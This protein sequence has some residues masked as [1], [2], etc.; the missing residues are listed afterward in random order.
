MEVHLNFLLNEIWRFVPAGKK[1][2]LL[3]NVS[4]LLGVFMLPLNDCIAVILLI[5]SC[6]F[7]YRTLSILTQMK[8]NLIPISLTIL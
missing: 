6:C 7:D 3:K 8:N 4:L 5:N 1:E 2:K